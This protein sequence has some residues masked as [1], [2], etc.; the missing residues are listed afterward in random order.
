MWVVMRWCVWVQGWPSNLF[1]GVGVFF[2]D[3]CGLWL[4]LGFVVIVHNFICVC[5]MLFFLFNC[6]TEVKLRYSSN[7]LTL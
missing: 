2:F 3:V 4:F 6:K 5:V 7:E 1:V